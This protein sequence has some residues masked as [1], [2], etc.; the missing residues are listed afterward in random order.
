[1]H[2]AARSAHQQNRALRAA[3]RIARF[4]QR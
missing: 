2:N 3:P 4:R 1:L